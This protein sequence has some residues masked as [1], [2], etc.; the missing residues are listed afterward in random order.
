MEWY[1]PVDDI[2][3]KVTAEHFC[4]SVF[5]FEKSVEPLDFFS[6]SFTGTTIKAVLGKSA[7]G[8]APRLSRE[9]RLFHVRPRSYAGADHVAAE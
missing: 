9:V 5:S 8:L 2:A 3:T 1:R 4:Y 7:F 6:R